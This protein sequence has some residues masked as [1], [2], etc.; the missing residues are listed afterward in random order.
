MLKIASGNVPSTACKEAAE[1]E[2]E[3]RVVVGEEDCPPTGTIV[4]VGVV[5]DTAEVRLD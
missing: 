3:D 1:E 5:L 4:I 2:L